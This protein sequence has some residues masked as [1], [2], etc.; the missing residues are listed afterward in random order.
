MGMAPA[1]S[2]LSPFFRSV[3]FILL[4]FVCARVCECVSVCSS[5]YAMSFLVPLFF[6]SKFSISAPCACAPVQNCMLMCAR[7]AACMYFCRTGEAENQVP[8]SFSIITLN[9]WVRVVRGS[10]LKVPLVLVLVLVRYPLT[11]W[12]LRVVNRYSAVSS[13]SS[14]RKLI[15]P[16]FP[17]R[18]PVETGGRSKNLARIFLSTSVML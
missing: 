11:L 13:I 3:C 5:G 15:A 18:R 4:L 14:R 1:L 10:C 2:L 16:A 8:F 9:E 6:F 12:F 7:S 17:S